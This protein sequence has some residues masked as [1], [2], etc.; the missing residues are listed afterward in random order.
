MWKALVYGHGKRVEI[1]RTQSHVA[2]KK[3]QGDIQVIAAQ[4]QQYDSQVR[5]A[6]ATLEAAKIN[7]DAQV[8]RNSSVSAV[9]R[10]DADVEST[11]VDADTRAFQAQTERENARLAVVM[12][13]AEL[14]LSQ[15][16]QRASLLL[17]AYE[18]AGSAS[19][20]LAA[21]AFSTMNFSA[22]VSS[23]VGKSDS[24]S[25]NFSFSGEIIDS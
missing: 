3:K 7:V 5:G 22:G 17:R 18:S 13:D 20:Q 12:K 9:Y 25:T 6:L 11:A 10:I 14:Q 21:S 16:I 19:S 24:C 2:K 15:M 4:L 1:Y 8:A 23:S